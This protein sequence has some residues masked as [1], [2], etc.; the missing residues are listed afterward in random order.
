MVQLLVYSSGKDGGRFRLWQ[1]TLRVVAVVGER[2]EL[3][4]V[5]VLEKR[6]NYFAI[7]S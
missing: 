6:E 7:A 5:S 4:K 2:N 1:H 3:A